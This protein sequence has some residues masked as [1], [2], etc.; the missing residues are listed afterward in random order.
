[1]S[2][3]IKPEKQK[4]SHEEQ[5]SEQQGSP[6]PVAAAASPGPPSSL[7][8]P[9]YQAQSN[10][11]LKVEVKVNAEEVQRFLKHVV[12]GAQPEAEDMLKNNRALALISGTVIDHAE[13]QLGD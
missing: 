6:S 8:T 13:N 10:S 7:I 1:M 11:S 12:A 9:Q 2:A 5:G 3:V 4:A